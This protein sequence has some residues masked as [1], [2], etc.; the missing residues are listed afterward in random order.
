MSTQMSCYIAPKCTD[1]VL[2]MKAMP[3]VRNLARGIACKLNK[4]RR[5]ELSQ[6]N[7]TKFRIV[8]NKFYAI[9]IERMRERLAFRFGFPKWYHLRIRNETGTVLASSL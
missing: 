7:K 8:Q 4:I 5:D 2:N 9:P 3:R 1:D 6:S